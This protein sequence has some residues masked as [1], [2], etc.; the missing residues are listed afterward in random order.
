M[1]LALVT[2]PHSRGNRRDPGLRARLLAAMA[3]GTLDLSGEDGWAPVAQALVDGGVERV[4]ISGGDGTLHCL[5][6]ALARMAPPERW[7]A[8]GLL[9]TGTMNTLAANLGVRGR[10]LALAAGLGAGALRPVPVIS[11]EDRVGVLFGV[12]VQV[13]FLE[14]YYKGLLGPV[15]GA[16]LLARVVGGALVSS[17]LARRLVALHRFRVEVD[18]VPWE[19]PGWRGVGASTLPSLGLGF[20]TCPNTPAEGRMEAYGFATAGGIVRN[21]PRMRFG[22]DFVGAGVEQSLATSLVIEGDE[23]LA[24]MVDGDLHRGG[25]RLEV[26]VTG[27]VR[28][29]VSGGR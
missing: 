23:P 21:L 14:E 19:Q 9:R 5:L 17:P 29:V 24:Y 26:S 11:V 3:E 13:S 15:G 7:P 22:L 12:G 10:P 25:R 16:W 2:N 8:V 4:G 20:Q 27:P 6:T 1:R 28:F 18:G